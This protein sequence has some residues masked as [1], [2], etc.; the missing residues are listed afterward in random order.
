MTPRQSST[1][2]AWLWLAFFAAVAVLALSSGCATGDTVRCPLCGRQAQCIAIRSDG[3]YRDYVC[4]SSLH[5]VQYGYNRYGNWTCLEA[6]WV[7]Q[8]AESSQ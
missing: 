3:N 2:C 1:T 6:K 4:T 5:S 7:P 8:K